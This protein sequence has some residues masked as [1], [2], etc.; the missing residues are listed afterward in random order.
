FDEYVLRIVNGEVKQDLI[1]ILK[2]IFSLD[3]CNVYEMFEMIQEGKMKEF[4][5]AYQEILFNYP[6]YFDLKDEN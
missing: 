6:S 5:E 4:E 3:D 1:Q 2:R